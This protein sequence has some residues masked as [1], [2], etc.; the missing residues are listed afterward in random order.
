MFVFLCEDKGTISGGH[1]FAET[2]SAIFLQAAFFSRATVG[3]RGS[4]M[5]FMTLSRKVLCKLNTVDLVMVE[6]MG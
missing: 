4:I 3:P 6:K 5:L 2:F 1:S